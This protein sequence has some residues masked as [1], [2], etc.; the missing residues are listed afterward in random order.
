MA[1]A[2]GVFTGAQVG[3]EKFS[4]RTVPAPTTTTSASSRIT[5]EQRPVAEHPTQPAGA[6][7]GGGGTVQAGD[8]VGPDSSSR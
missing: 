7:A 1:L 8:E 4:V 5:P 2:L 3:P 6:S